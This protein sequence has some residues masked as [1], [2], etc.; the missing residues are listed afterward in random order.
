MAWRPN[1]LPYSAIEPRIAVCASSSYSKHH[2]GAIDPQ[3]AVAS[4]AP[5]APETV[6]GR[7][8]AYKRSRAGPGAPQILVR[9]P[10]TV[11]PI[12]GPIKIDVAFIP[13]GNAT[14]DADSFR[15]RYGILGIDVTDR[16]KRYAAVTEAGVRADLPSMPKGKHSFELQIADSLNAR[17]AHAL[18]V[19]YRRNHRIVGKRCVAAS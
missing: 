13:S 17:E 14:I 19:M 11:N 3:A 6:E 9:S 4:R 18:N 15:V 1:G 10:D 16:V 2:R 7:D 8:K 12:T 5:N